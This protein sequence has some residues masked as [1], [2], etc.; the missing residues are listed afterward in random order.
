[1]LSQYQT[2]S[3]SDLSI[4]LP[5][6]IAGFYNMDVLSDKSSDGTVTTLMTHIMQKDALSELYKSEL[7]PELRKLDAFS[8]LL[9]HNRYPPKR[10]LTGL[11]KPTEAI[12]FASKKGPNIDEESDFSFSVINTLWKRVG[13]HKL[14]LNIDEK[15]LTASL[16]NVVDWSGCAMS[17]TFLDL[18]TLTPKSVDSFLNST[19]LDPKTYDDATE[20]CDMVLVPVRITTTCD[21]DDDERLNIVCKEQLKVGNEIYKD[22]G[23]E[24][25]GVHDD[26]INLF[27]QVSDIRNEELLLENDYVLP[28]QQVN[29][30]FFDAQGT[31]VNISVLSK[32]SPACNSEIEQSR[33][34]AISMANKLSIGLTA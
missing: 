18:E 26:A 16:Q 6:V 9:M 21:V 3:Q 23:F 20:S 24:L 27:N 17:E 15:K 4:S 32:H 7:F 5:C 11:L 22:D 34:K 25:I 33:M 10:T 31:P 19:S 12:Q 28:L 1:M 2:T 14:N 13:Q 30:D 29:D 8:D